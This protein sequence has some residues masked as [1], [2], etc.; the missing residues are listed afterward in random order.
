M[1]TMKVKINIIGDSI[2]LGYGLSSEDES[3]VN[4]L[5]KLNPFEVSVFAKCG[6][7]LDAVFHDLNL[8]SKE[9]DI[10]VIFIGTNGNIESK[11][12]LSLIHYLKTPENHIIICNLMIESNNNIIINTIPLEEGITICDLNKQVKNKEELMQDDNIHPNVKG[13]RVIFNELFRIIN[14]WEK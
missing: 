4:L 7:D 11:K 1:S 13:H 5:A 3:Y 8:M 6:Y 2:S 14:S 9:S 12:L 10:W